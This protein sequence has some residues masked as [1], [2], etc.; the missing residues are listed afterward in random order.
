MALYTC[1]CS[2]IVLDFQLQP[3]YDGSL[4][5]AGINQETLNPVARSHAALT[6]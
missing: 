4:W 1:T 2:Y 5:P 3:Y 6:V